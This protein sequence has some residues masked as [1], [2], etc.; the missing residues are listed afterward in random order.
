MESSQRD[1]C[2]Q[3]EGIRGNTRLC[4]MPYC[5]GRRLHTR[6]KGV[7]TYQSFGLDKKLSNPIGLLNFLE[8]T[9]G[10][11]P[12]DNGVADRGLTTWLRHQIFDCPNIIA[13]LFLFVKCFF[14]L[15]YAFICFWITKSCYC[16]CKF[17]FIVLKCIYKAVLMP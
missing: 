11:E 7:I 13:E 10:F 14:I 3:A 4:V 8:V 6:P 9:A 5:T 15:F 16:Y 1:V 17:Q 2:Y 12:A